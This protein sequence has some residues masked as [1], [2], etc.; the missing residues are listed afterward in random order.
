M[1]K[2]RLPTLP[3]TG[4]R[5]IPEFMGFDPREL[6]AHIARYNFALQWCSDHSN[7]PYEPKKHVL[8]A[9][10]G[11]GYGTLM[12]SW[13]S[14]SVGV[15]RDED[16]IRYARAKYS[17][18]RT[19]FEV[20]NADDIRLPDNFFDV[21]VA[22]EIIE[23]LLDP[24]SFLQELRRVVKPKGTLI[25]SV[26]HYS[27][28]KYH[29]RDYDKQSLKNMLNQFWSNMT[30]YCQDSRLNFYSEESDEKV[31]THVFVVNQ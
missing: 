18:P 21:A 11:T 12:L 10:C 2:E 5:V 22:F 26:P 20:S 8:D 16:A 28:S 4:E 17:T 27:E 24:E 6:Q 29:F 25:I 3:W 15:D 14:W 1:D 30:Y 9:G 23:H 7:Y 19:R 31:R 13:V